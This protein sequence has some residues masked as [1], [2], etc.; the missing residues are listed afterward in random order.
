MTERE[1]QN[2]EIKSDIRK[3]ST[4]LFAFAV[5][6]S[7]LSGR[8]CEHIDGNEALL[9]FHERNTQTL[10]NEIDANEDAKVI[11]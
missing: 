9:K 6:F 10:C 11:G 4:A 7:T 8:L 5:Q 2:E 1:K 3:L